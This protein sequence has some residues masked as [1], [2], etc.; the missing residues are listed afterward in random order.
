MGCAEG[1]IINYRRRFIDECLDNLN[2]IHGVTLFTNAN[3]PRFWPNNCHY[4]DLLTVI[5]LGFAAS[6]NGI[7]GKE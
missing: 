7:I 1:I 3:Y 2:G 4:S 6:V 5:V